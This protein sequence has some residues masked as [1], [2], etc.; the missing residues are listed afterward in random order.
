MIQ[1][2]RGG[3]RG[4]VKASYR[5]TSI[6]ASDWQAVAAFYEDVFGCEPAPPRR[7]LSGAWLDKGTGVRGAH[8]TGIHLLLPGHGERGPTLEIFGY[9]RSEPRPAVAAN[10]EGIA[11]IAFEVD[12]VAAAVRNVLEHGGSRVGDVAS[13]EVPGAGILTFVYV[14]DP[15]GNIVELQAWT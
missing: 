14:A 2:A 5:H 1:G 4:V 7:D 11:H 12:D 9:A 3:Q 8:I 6:V 13:S 10:R 15:E